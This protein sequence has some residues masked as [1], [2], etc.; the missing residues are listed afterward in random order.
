MKLID[1]KMSLDT[2]RSYIEVWDCKGCLPYGETQHNVM[3]VD[4][5]QYL[6]TIDAEPVRHG[7]WAKAGDKQYCT[8]CYAVTKVRNAPFCWHCGAK[9]DLR[10]PT[11]VQLDE[12]DSV[13]MGGAEN[14]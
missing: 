1:P 9:I 14:G 7:R 10:T 5:L 13:M 12:A 6:P 8:E 3:A 11:E 4:D 2:I